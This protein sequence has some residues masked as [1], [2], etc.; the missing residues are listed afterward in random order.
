MELRVLLEELLRRLPDL[1]VQVDTPEYQF[2]GGDYA[3]FGS[4]PVS[5]TPGKPEGNGRR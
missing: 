5:F 2:G 4:L 1:C 3:F